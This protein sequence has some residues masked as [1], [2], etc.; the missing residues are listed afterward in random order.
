M[1]HIS[2]DLLRLLN[3]RSGLGRARR[4]AAK[5]KSDRLARV[6]GDWRDAGQSGDLVGRG[7]RLGERHP[8]LD[9]GVELVCRNILGG[10]RARC[11]PI[12]AQRVGESEVLAKASVGAGLAGRGVQQGSGFLRLAGECDREAVVGRLEHSAS[13]AKH[14]ESLA[15]A[16]LGDLDQRELQHDLRLLGDQRERVAV[17]GF[18]RSEPARSEIAVAEQRPEAR[19]VG[20]L[21][22][23]PLGEVHR[24]RKIILVESVERPHRKTDVSLVARVLEDGRAASGRGGATGDDRGQGDCR[25]CGTEA[26]RF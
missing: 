6:A 17:G 7:A 11:V 24:G 23:R 13:I 12:A 9:S 8:L 19:V 4:R 5:R 16:A 2:R 15:I 1:G 26:E 18:G 10:N 3:R 25:E 22:D 14:G 20:A 21:L